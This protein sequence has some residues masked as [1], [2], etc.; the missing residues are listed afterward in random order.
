MLDK[1]NSSSKTIFNAKETLFIPPEFN[2][3]EAQN[4]F[5]S[6]DS[7]SVTRVTKQILKTIS[8]KSKVFTSFVG[9]L[10]SVGYN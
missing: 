6:N 8:V 4:F 5:E 3:R 2:Y 9:I 7:N 1:D 10:F